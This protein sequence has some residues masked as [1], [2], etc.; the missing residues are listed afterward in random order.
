MSSSPTCCK[1]HINKS[2]IGEGKP[3]LDK[4]FVGHYILA[5]AFNTLEFAKKSYNL[6]SEVCVCILFK[7]AK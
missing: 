5:T 7:Q 1:I 3:T 6:D 4:M 2:N